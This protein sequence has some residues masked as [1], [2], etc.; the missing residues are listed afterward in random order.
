MTY[1]GIEQLRELP[2][3]LSMP[4]P[5]EWEDRNGH[6]NVQFYLA[7]YELG[8]WVVLEEIGVDEAW[9]S[10]HQVSQFDLEHHLYYR[11]EL[12]VGDQVSTYSRVLGRS[13]TRF[14]GMYF[15]VN[16][17]KQ[18]LA[19]TLE[20]VTASI[21]MKTRRTVP[22]REELANGLDGLIEKHRG[23]SWAAPVCADMS[24]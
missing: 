19:A 4:I 1:P 18:R 22:F 20:Y 11:A 16:E 12:S 21:D 8:G 6:V 7:L 13:D 2:L 17:T 15:I 9:F 3:Q 24:P 10:R 23:L 14:H 5:P